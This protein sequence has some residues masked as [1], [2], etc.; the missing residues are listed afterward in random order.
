MKRMIC[1]AILSA[2]LAL[3]ATPA[4]AHE[5]SLWD[6]PNNTKIDVS[7]ASI[8]HGDKLVRGRITTRDAVSD[9]TLKNRGF[10]RFHFWE[11]GR[12]DEAVFAVAMFRTSKGM[13]ARIYRFK[14]DNSTFIGMGTAK[15]LARDEFSFTASRSKMGFADPTRIKWTAFGYWCPDAGCDNP[16]IDWVPNTGSKGHFLE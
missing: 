2:A 1:A 9:Y 12:S 15:R 13:R 10:F 5:D 16:K 4:A 3:G 7:Q 6:G 11:A 8:G 14:G